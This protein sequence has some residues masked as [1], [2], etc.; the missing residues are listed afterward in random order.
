LK[1]EFALGRSMEDEIEFASSHFYE[2]N[3]DDMIG[4]DVSILERIV[5][6]QSLRLESEDSLLEFICSLES[7]EETVLLRYVRSEY[8]S[9]DGIRLLV[10][11]LQ[12]SNLDP[13]V[14]ES[15]RR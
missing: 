4:L 5:S 10:D 12:D 15:L 6:S 11:H 3:V 1:G 2:L 7:E 13:F 9:H 8:L 14:W